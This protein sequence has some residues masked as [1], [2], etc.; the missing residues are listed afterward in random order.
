MPPQ[1]TVQDFM[2]RYCATFTPGNAAAM[3]DFFHHP[4]AMIFGGNFLLLNTPQELTTT[5][6]A[7]LAGLAA[8][9]F[10]HST[11]DRL[12]VTQLADQTF[13]VT[14]A[15]TRYHRD[16]SVLETVGATYTLLAGDAGFRIAMVVA[17]DAGALE[18]YRAALG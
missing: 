12:A 4:V 10:S 7:M 11:P 13:W 17:H 6:E 16:G 9:G 18:R 5:F 2:G 1:Q 14:G 8:R 15:F 3:A